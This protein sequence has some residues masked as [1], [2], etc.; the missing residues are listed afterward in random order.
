MRVTKPSLISS[1]VVG[2]LAVS[3]AGVAAQDG[4]PGAASY[5][6]GTIGGSDVVG[7]PTDAFEDGILKL[8]GLEREGPI[9]TTDPRMTGLLA[10][11]IDLD[12]HLAGEGEE[13]AILTVQYQIVNDE[14]SW[15]GT[16]PGVGFN[17]ADV[18]AEE[19][20]DF[21][22]ALLTGEGAYDGLSAILLV[23][24]AQRD[25]GGDIK[26]VIYPGELPLLAASMSDE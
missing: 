18:A 7:E 13:V 2:L 1:L 3:V 6:T 12:V 16:S 9:D 17:G 23:D 4:G 8:R 10:R 22:T 20:V 19:E 25:G 21:Q 14:G 26:G 5:F 11:A 15:S 24:F